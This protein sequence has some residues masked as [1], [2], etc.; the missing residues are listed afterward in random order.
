MD[1]KNITIKTC[2]FKNDFGGLICTFTFEGAE[3]VSTLIRIVVDCEETGADVIIT[4]VTTF[5][6]SKTKNGYGSSALQS[7]L[8]RAVKNN[9]KKIVAV[10]VQDVCEGFWIKNGFRKTENGANDFIFVQ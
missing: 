1:T 8:S 4:Y 7:L 3:D 2:S 10:D 5:P 9:M 6:F